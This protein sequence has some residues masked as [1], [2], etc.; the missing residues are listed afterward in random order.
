MYLGEYQ[1]SRKLRAQMELGPDKEA[2][3]A[4]DGGAR[5]GSIRS[6]LQRCIL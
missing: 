3:F 4:V 1:Y 6:S 2:A 5:H